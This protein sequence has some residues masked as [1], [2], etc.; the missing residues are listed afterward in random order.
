MVERRGEK[1]DREKMVSAGTP[2][3]LGWKKV[4]GANLGSGLV[5]S[6]L[7]IGNG[8]ASDSVICPGSRGGRVAGPCIYMDT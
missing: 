4:P 3:W 7:G 2:W 5:P 6:G 1:R 8:L